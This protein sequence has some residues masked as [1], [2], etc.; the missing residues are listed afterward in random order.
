MKKIILSSVLFLISI[1]AFCQQQE[2][3]IIY[4][5]HPY[6]EVVNQANRDYVAQN[7]STIKNYFADTARWWVSGLEDF[8]P[9]ADA[10]NLWKND[11]EHFD[12]INQTQFGYPDFLHY[13]KANSM[14][15]QSWWTWTG[16]SKKTGEVLKIPM[17]QFDEF[18][19]DGKIVRE[20]IF[21]D[22]SKMNN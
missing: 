13:K 5:K 15:V 20:Y 19:K 9:I 8:I 6:I 4:I 16:K 11:F 18:N 17:V 14:V 7:F 2:N 12:N 21:G 10:V 22:F 3:G 1:S